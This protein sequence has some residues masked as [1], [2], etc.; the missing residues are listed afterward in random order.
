MTVSK[1]ILNAYKFIELTLSSAFVCTVKTCSRNSKKT[2]FDKTII[3]TNLRSQGAGTNTFGT[4]FYNFF[5][6]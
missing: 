5:R 6:I 3:G 1:G 2:S 4:R